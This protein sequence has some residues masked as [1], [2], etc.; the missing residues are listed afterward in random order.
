MLYSPRN[1]NKNEMDW[2][3]SL[4]RGLAAIAI[5]A[6]YAFTLIGVVAIMVSNGLYHFAVATLVV[7]AFAS[8]PMYKTFQKMVM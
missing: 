6:A 2:L 1:K 8:K 3:K 4:G 5:L 7:V